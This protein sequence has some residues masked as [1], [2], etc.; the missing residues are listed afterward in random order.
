MMRALTHIGVC[1]LHITL[2]AYQV[3]GAVAREKFSVDID[4][5][6]IRYY[7]RIFA[8]FFF[9]NARNLVF[10]FCVWLQ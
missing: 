7:S 1:I 8:L 3:F 5:T 4:N 9:T 2:L 10:L 6:T